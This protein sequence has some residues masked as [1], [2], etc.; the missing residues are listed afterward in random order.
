QR[1]RVRAYL[2]QRQLAQKAGVATSTV[3]R[4][5]QGYPMSMLVT[6]RIADALGVTVHA[7]RATP[8]DE[9]A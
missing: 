8:P 3:A 5:E 6:Q 7:L 9:E 1:A 4:A 2:T